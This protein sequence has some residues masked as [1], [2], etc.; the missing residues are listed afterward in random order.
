MP[1]IRKV[2]VS[3]E[4]PT[5]TLDAFAKD[6]LDTLPHCMAREGIHVHAGSR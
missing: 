2:P 5:T 4:I 3:L 1:T 6:Q